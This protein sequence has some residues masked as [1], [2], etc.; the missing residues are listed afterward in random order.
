MPD[1]KVT[2]VIALIM[3]GIIFSAVAALDY[4]LAQIEMVQQ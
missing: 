4:R 2:L 1:I 3:G